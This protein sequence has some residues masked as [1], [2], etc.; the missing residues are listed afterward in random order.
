[1]KLNTKEIELLI[2]ST[3]LRPN[4]T[5]EEIKNHCK[6]AKEYKFKSVA[7]NSSQVKK[8]K[9]LLEDSGVLVGAAISFPLG[10]TTIETKLSEIE[11]A[12]QDGVDEIDYVINIGKVKDSDFNYIE[13]EM[14]RIV[15]LCRRHKVTSKVILE[16][17]YLTK[18]EI[19]SV[20][21]IARKIRPNF[22]KTSTGFGTAGACVEDVEL[23]KSIVHD[24]VA[25]KASGGIRDLELLEKMISVGA[26]R[27]GTSKGAQIIKQINS[28]K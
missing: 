11:N 14:K 22:V 8:C 25:I 1:M 24:E 15:E 4:V 7:V 6:E 27:I 13:E 2:D 9:E 23:M 18:E 19:V 16:T 12:I 20:S 26:T 21:T 5:E 10:Q 3:L 28:I 17:C